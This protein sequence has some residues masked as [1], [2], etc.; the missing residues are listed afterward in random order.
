[1]GHITVG[2]PEATVVTGAP[3]VPHGAG[4]SSRVP[5]QADRHAANGTGTK[6]NTTGSW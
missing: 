6:T 4:S 5:C 1:M 2:V 3:T